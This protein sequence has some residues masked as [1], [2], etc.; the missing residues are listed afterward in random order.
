MYGP[1][2]SVV[3]RECVYIVETAGFGKETLLTGLE[4]GISAEP[5]V[6]DSTIDAAENRP[7]VEGR[8]VFYPFSIMSLFGYQN[9]PV[10]IPGGVFRPT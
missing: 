6:E 10:G 2:P 3:N 5:N 4:I 8:I 1:C 9:S 7:N